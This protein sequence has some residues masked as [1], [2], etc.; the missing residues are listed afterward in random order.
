VDLL[1]TGNTAE[2]YV[3]GDPAGGRVVKLDK[4]EWNGL[5][6]YEAD[7]LDKVVAAGIAAPR[8]FERVTV[9]GRDG[10][11]LERIDGPS[12]FDVLLEAPA[13]AEAWAQRMCDLQ[14]SLHEMRIDAVPDLV[15]RLDAELASC[16][17]E[18]ALVEE[19][20]GTLVELDRGERVLCHWD[21]H[22]RNVLLGADGPV[23][24]DWLTVASGPAVADLARSMVLLDDFDRNNP[25]WPTYV[26]ATRRL[27]AEARGVTDHELAGWIRIAA[28]G[29]LM[30]GFTGDTAA[31]LRAIARAEH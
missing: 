10:V 11:V 28:A 25:W 30:E 6:H 29:R 1:A 15:S 16:G 20:R 13:A 21:F 22:P 5:S 9:D 24:I 12:V 4:P 19:L 31:R 27:G 8:A 17:L 7:V 14:M 18:P 2:V 23:V 26:G 3:W